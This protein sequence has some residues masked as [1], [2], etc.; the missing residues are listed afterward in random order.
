MAGN[1]EYEEIE[2]SVDVREIRRRDGGPMRDVVRLH[3]HQETRMFPSWKSRCRIYT[4]LKLER[5]FVTVFEVDGLVES[6]RSQPLALKFV[7]DGK[8]VE[9][10]GLAWID[11][12]FGKSTADIE[13]AFSNYIRAQH[14]YESDEDL[15]FAEDIA[16][17]RAMVSRLIDPE[18]AAELFVSSRGLLN[19]SKEASSK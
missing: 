3:P 10:A 13:R 7:L 16:Q 15:K 6:Y 1:P 19:S 18:K 4:T 12:R 11:E 14:A 8:P 9:Y 2:F 17:Q 5:A